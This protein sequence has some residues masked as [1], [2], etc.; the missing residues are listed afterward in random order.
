VGSILGG[1]DDYSDSM[2]LTAGTA[3]EGG[4]KIYIILY[5]AKP[6]K[7]DCFSL[8]LFPFSG[9]IL[10]FFLSVTVHITKVPLRLI[11]GWNRVL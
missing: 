7:L 8:G 11:W 10:R 5:S 6:C 9:S 1:A 3:Y 4:I 2:N